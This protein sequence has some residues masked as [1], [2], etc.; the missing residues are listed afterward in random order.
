VRFGLT[1]AVQPITTNLATEESGNQGI[2]DAGMERKGTGM[3]IGQST[4]TGNSEGF[5]RRKCR[6]AVAGF[7]VS[8]QRSAGLGAVA[9]KEE[10]E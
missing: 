6:P 5:E 7:L 9:G 8:A 4:F 3:N 2:R 10:R 1:D